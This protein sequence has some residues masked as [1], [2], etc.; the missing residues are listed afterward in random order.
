VV[1]ESRE[2]EEEA[3]E[4]DIGGAKMLCQC[5]GGAAPPWC[6]PSLPRPMKALES[7]ASS[8]PPSSPSA[9]TCATWRLLVVERAEREEEAEL[10]GRCMGCGSRCRGSGGAW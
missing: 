2:E 7:S 4:E 6:S 8:P 5:P 3:E 1:P 9:P 10:R